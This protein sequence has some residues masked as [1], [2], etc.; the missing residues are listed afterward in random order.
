MSVIVRKGE[1]TVLDGPRVSLVG[2]IQP[3]VFRHL[4]QKNDEL[5]MADG[6]L[7]R[8]LLTYDSESYYPRSRT[9]WP[10]QCQEYWDYI[11]TQASEWADA[12]MSCQT[13]FGD[14]APLD[15]KF[16]PQARELFYNFTERMLQEQSSLDALNDNSLFQFSQFI[17]KAVT[18]VIRVAGLLHILHALDKGVDIDRSGPIR[19]ETVWGL[20]TWY[21][22]TWVKPLI[23]P[24][25]TLQTNTKGNQEMNTEL[26][27][28]DPERNCIVIRV[29]GVYEYEIDRER[30]KTP[31]SCLDWIHQVHE[32]RWGSEIMEEFLEVLFAEIPGSFW[33]GHMWD[34][35]REKVRN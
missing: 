27:R 22:F 4:L 12:R 23:P 7:F 13:E 34:T 19:K 15:I 2:G 14:E 25:N 5:L 21:S 18:A 30:L 16:E 17:P 8:F 1:T 29:S 33:I 26:C 35:L 9:G 11:T 32:K 3:H 6:T 28:F 31:A 24:Q 10:A 20:A